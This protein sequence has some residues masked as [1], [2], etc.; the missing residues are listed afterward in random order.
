MAL[1]TVLAEL[2]HQREVQKNKDLFA[3]SLAVAIPNNT[4]Q[5]SVTLNVEND[6]DFVTEQILGHVIGPANEEG[7]RQ[8]DAE[9]DYPLVGTTLGY[10][11]HGLS[12]RITDTSDRPMTSGFIPVELLLTPGY[13]EQF[14]IPLPWKKLFAAKSRIKFEFK[15]RDT[16]TGPDGATLYH[17][18]SIVIKGYK[19][20]FAPGEAVT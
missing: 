7:V 20:V 19:Y 12:M 10:A 16:K 2:K 17:Y 1:S 5:Q 8:L 18:V 6:A 3:Y 13:R 14:Y 15:N 11:E 9:T 4:E